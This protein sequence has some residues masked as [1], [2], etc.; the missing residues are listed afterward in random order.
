VFSF[1]FNARI[2]SGVDPA[3]AAGVLVYAQ[4]W[5]RD[6]LVGSTTGLTD[7]LQFGIGF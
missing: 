3:L 6:P 7:G 4:Y 5:Y 1:D 2:Q